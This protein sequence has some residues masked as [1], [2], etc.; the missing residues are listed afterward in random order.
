MYK[1]PRGPGK[2]VA[3]VAPGVPFTPEGAVGGHVE[4]VCFGIAH[5]PVYGEHRSNRASPSLVTRHVAAFA[6]H[7]MII[8]HPDGMFAGHLQGAAVGQVEFNERLT[9]TS[10]RLQASVGRTHEAA[11]NSTTRALVLP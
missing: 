6:S 11:C 4:G 5:A 10:I 3:I 8:I 9:P 7:L 2:K 1:H